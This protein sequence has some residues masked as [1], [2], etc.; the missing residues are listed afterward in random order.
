MNTDPETSGAT[1]LPFPARRRALVVVEG[2]RRTGQAVSAS[3]N[4]ADPRPPADP[5]VPDWPPPE[6]DAFGEPIILD[7]SHSH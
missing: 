2:G 4:E 1:I 7:F 5:G 3:S 6:I